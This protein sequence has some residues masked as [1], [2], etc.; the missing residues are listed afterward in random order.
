MKLR[1]ILNEIGDTI[2]IPHGINVVVSEYS[3]NVKFKFL[4]VF[5][6]IEIRIPIKQDNKIVVSVDFYTTT[7]GKR[8]DPQTSYNI[9]NQ[10]QALKVMSYI[11]GSIEYW[12]KQY[13][14]KFFKS[15]PLQ[16]IYIKFDPKAEEDESG[17]DNR[18]NKLYQAFITKFAKRYGST[19]T[20]SNTGGI[21]A[22][23]NP[24]LTLQ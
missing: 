17:A 12:L 19:V 15:I 4:D 11:V 7:D 23:F 21:T 9:T 10:H 6:T 16:L 3:G 22:K 13:K 20:F 5:Y 2:N 24:E 8:F 1:W 14:D 18:R